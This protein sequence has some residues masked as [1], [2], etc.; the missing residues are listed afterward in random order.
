MYGVRA[1]GTV[2]TED[3]PPVNDRA[4]V[5]VG[6]RGVAEAIP[7][8]RF[9]TRSRSVKEVGREGAGPGLTSHTT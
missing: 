3:D 5:P 9:P 6:G 8:P 2:T 4:R 7:D 1:D